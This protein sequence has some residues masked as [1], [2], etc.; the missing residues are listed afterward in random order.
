MNIKHI[1][2]PYR[3]RTA[4]GLVPDELNNEQIAD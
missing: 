2:Q 3:A 4:Q 1:P